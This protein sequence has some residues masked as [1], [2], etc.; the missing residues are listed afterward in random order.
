MLRE[1]GGTSLFAAKFREAASRAL[2]LPKRR[3]GMRAPLWQQRKRAADLLAVAARFSSFPIILETYRECLRDVFDLPAAAAILTKISRGEIRITR[4]ESNK[5]SPFA[6]ALLFSYI[7]NYIYEGDA[8]LAERRAQALSIDQSQLEELLGDTDLRELL[9][10]AALDEVESRLQL[11]EPDYRARHADGVHDMLLKLGDLS[12]EEIAARAASPE[13]AATIAD[14]VSARRAVRVKIAGDSRSIPVEY[15]GR[16]RDAFGTPLPPGLAEVFLAKGAEDPLAEI[17]RRYA[18]THGPFTTADIARRYQLPD[19]SIENVLRLLNSQGKLL[20]GEFRPNGRHREWCDPEVLRQI[21]RKSLAR[22]RRE[23]EP[24][25]QAT[26][27]R[28]VTRWQGVTVPRRGLDALL[29]TIEALQGTA[30]LASE[31]ETEILP[32][33]VSDYEPGYL[34]TLMAAGEVTWVGL[35]Q[36]GDRN[37]RIALFLTGALPLLRLPESAQPPASSRPRTDA[38]SDATNPVSPHADRAAKIA[39][40]LSRQGASFFS[41]I[42]AAC[43]GGFPGDT[44]D[45]L[46]ELAW[47]GRITNDTFYPLRRL[48]RP[49]D[50]KRKHEAFDDERPGSPGYLRRV[51]SR[52]GSGQAHGR[53]SLLRQPITAAITPTQ[54]S[55]NTA[56]QLLQRHGILMRESAIAENIPGGYQTIYPALKTMEDSGW[57]R[58]G[59]FVAGLGA[60]QFAMPAAVD[61]LRSLRVDPSTPEVLH[62]A[63]TD[64]ANPY[65]ALLP[66]PK[67][68]GEA[69]E[70]SAPAHHSMARTAGASVILINGQL[71]AFIRRRN[72]AVR[73]FLPESEPDRGI[74]ARELSRKLAELAIKRLNRRQGLLIAEINGTPAR[75]HFLGGQLQDAGFVDTVLGYQMRRNRP[76]VVTPN[77]D[78]ATQPDEEEDPADIEETA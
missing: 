51:R 61:M 11:L 68:D 10:P 63:A 23:I 32:A 6:A 37:G 36:I 73:V 77:L 16:Y 20:E 74:F 3:H 12:D 41:E 14:L 59:M 62:L 26:Y 38:Q 54:W 66:W 56:Q 28:F 43:G 50:R 70:Q 47:A 33:R 57:V 35:E 22:L 42:H 45:A 21:R 34:D 64:P 15:A 78:P 75:Q 25:E 5:P 8:P 2:L 67:V 44:V 52:T 60:A 4:V 9:D 55:A 29:D 1:L 27:V 17:L 65:G 53:W 69:D 40:F 30:L 49:E 71:A 58:R 24:V 72:P 13:V 46:W 19:S 39:E 48:L 76:L 31:L 7:A 18:R